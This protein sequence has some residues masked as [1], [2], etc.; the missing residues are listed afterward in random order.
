MNLMRLWEDLSG[1]NKFGICAVIGLIVI[2]LLLYI[3]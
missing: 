3:F 2:L 1:W